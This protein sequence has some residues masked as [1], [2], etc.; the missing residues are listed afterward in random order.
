MTNK[1]L[2]SDLGAVFTVDPAV[3]LW[4]YIKS[5]WTTATGYTVP[6]A[7]AIKFDTKFGEMK[8]FYNYFVVENMPSSIKPQVLGGS[9][10]TVEEVKRIQILCIGKSAKDTKWK[11]EKHIESLLN[12]NLLGM[13]GTY[14]IKVMNIS[15]FQD[16][17]TSETESAITGLQPNTGFHKARS[18]AVVRLQY[19]LESTTA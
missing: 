17:P 13:Q 11:M 2:N 3:G 12:G 10:Y 14:G 15:S 1:L 8:G 5:I 18:F 16:I 9:R 4:T 7:S 19:E 6:A